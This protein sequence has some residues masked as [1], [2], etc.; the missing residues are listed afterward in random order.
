MLDAD[1]V[2]LEHD[3][4]GLDDLVLVPEK[5]YSMTLQATSD[6]LGIFD[7]LSFK[8]NGFPSRQCPTTLKSPQF[9]KKLV[10]VG[11]MLEVQYYPHR[12]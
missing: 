8:N 6:A 1:G 9:A 11:G 3:G 5:T 2:E 12:R 10:G 4:Q 7:S